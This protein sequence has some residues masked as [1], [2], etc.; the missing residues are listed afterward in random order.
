[1]IHL[2]AILTTIKTRIV[3]INCQGPSIELANKNKLDF[4]KMSSSAP[5][6]NNNALAIVLGTVLGVFFLIGIIL[7]AV[8]ATK[9]EMYLRKATPK[10]VEL[11][12]LSDSTM[13]LEGITI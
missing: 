10:E 5:P 12:N 13:A 9:K 1:L 3:N 7:I 2:H 11:N 4:S 8:F 6:P